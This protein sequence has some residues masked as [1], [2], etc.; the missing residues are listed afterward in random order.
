MKKLIGGGESLDDIKIGL[1]T[2][3]IN[4]HKH[5]FRDPETKRLYAK[6]EIVEQNGEFLIYMTGDADTKIKR[7][8]YNNE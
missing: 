6:A 4:E 8:E 5:W 3:I 2:I 7:E 1:D